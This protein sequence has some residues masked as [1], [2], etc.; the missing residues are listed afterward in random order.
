[1]T[2]KKIRHSPRWKYRRTKPFVPLPDKPAEV[3]EGRPGWS[4]KEWSFVASLTDGQLAA[5]MR[6]RETWLA[7]GLTG[8]RAIDWWDPYNW[9][10]E[11]YGDDQGDFEKQERCVDDYGPEDFESYPVDFEA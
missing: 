3:E 8:V 1:V 11:R 6:F 9:K 7:S 4:L 2:V 5:A 10:R